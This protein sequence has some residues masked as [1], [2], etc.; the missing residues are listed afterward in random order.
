MKSQGKVPLPEMPGL[1]FAGDCYTKRGI[2]INAAANAAMTC[3][4]K[5]LEDPGQS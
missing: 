5:I 3:A 1:Y 2:G 4:D